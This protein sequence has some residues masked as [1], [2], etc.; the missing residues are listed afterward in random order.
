LRHPH[1]A[2]IH[3]AAADYISMQLVTGAPLDAIDRGERR[4]LVELLRDAARAVHHAH[5]QGIVHRDLK[6]S[7]LLVEGRHVFVV[8]FGLAKELAHDAQQSLSLSGAV[9]GTPSFMPPE[10]ALG[11]GELVDARS[12][13]YALGA[14]LY[15][16]LCGRP[17]FAD[18]DLPTLL[19][20]IVEDDPPPPGVDRDLDLVILK[21]LQKEPAQRYP[22]AQA[23]ADDLDRWLRNEPVTARRPS[24]GYRLRKHLQRRG[25]LLRAAA[26]TALAAV[27]LTALILGPIAL[28]ESAGRR[29]AG[30][31]VAL[32]E[33][34]T[35]VLQDAVIY[36]RLGDLPSAHAAL[37]RGIERA[38][39]FLARHDIARVHHLLSRL[40]RA[41][42]RDGEALVEL[43]AAIAGDPTLTEARF[44]RGLMLAAEL[45]PDAATRAQAV[46]DLS[47]AVDADGSVL[48][49]I[50]RLF[51]RAERLRLR[52]E[53][54]EATELLR[55]VLAYD[56]AHLG[57]RLSLSRIAYRQGDPSAQY[58]SASAV[59][60][61]QGFGPVFFARE[62]RQL[63]IS[64][65]G[66]E[67]ALVDFAQQLG[68]SPDDALAMAY[69][70]LVQLRRGLRLEREGLATDAL[71]ALRGAVEDYDLT[72]TIHGDHAGAWNNRA[73]CLMEV[74]RLAAAQGD[75]AAAG[76]A[77][78]RA[79]A[80]LVRARELAPDMLEAAFNQGLLALRSVEL[81]RRLGRPDAAVALGE[82]GRAA[83][84]AA[85]AA[86][87]DGWLHRRTCERL[88]GQ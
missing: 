70:G 75:S 13:V 15:R 19:R 37:D 3:D 30:E 40:L 20:R 24:F 35:A 53:L 28:R 29:A 9:L 21:C 36:T 43:Q 50:D 68:D 33:H 59:N 73:V 18:Q 81:M 57:A 48:T 56:P 1:I 54:E 82:R 78:V 4:L 71:A 79:E 27:L 61:Q 39:E 67:S 46:A 49:A 34:A 22:T 52:D 58:Y 11:R 64:I 63:P 38:R 88:L 65:L 2:A 17:P 7:N 62:Q 74:W 77:R 83:L 8:D 14:T 60:V 16:C 32:S 84:R 69:R 87:P 85:L 55:E 6:P 25:A 41:R 80:D 51:G 72:L 12:D 26:L 44:E 86:A 47:V 66:L 31:A 5:E 45:E 42:G 76:A 10:Q 23:L